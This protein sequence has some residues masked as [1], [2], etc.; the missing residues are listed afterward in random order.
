[1]SSARGRS[2]LFFNTALRILSS[3]QIRVIRVEIPNL[4]NDALVNFRR[5]VDFVLQESCGVLEGKS[6]SNSPMSMSSP[7]T[8]D[9]L[10]SSSQSSP[11]KW[12]MPV[13]DPNV[14]VW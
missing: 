5:V 13:G 9:C 10:V 14:G 7:S 12:T 1:M 11:K 2:P 3:S 8:L 6:F 4:E